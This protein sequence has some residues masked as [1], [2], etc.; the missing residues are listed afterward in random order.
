MDHLVLI[1][2]FAMLQ[3]A[4]FSSQ[5]PTA[6]G[7]IKPDIVAPGYRLLSAWAGMSCST[8]S[9]LGTHIVLSLYQCTA[10]CMQHQVIWYVSIAANNNSL[11]P[12]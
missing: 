4:Y 5:G 9:M 3:V 7:R 1:W 6:D 12:W 8:T 2:T 11:L 10:Y